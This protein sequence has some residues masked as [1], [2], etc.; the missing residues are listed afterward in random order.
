MTGL[1]IER[2]FGKAEVSQAPTPAPVLGAALASAPAPA[3]NPA[4]TP[5]AAGV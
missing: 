1:G 3:L 2:A 4:S 5:G